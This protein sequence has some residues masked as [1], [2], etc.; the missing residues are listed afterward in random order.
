MRG[1]R[2]VSNQRW[3]VQI[4]HE[5]AHNEASRPSTDAV[6]CSRMC[7]VFASRG[8]SQVSLDCQNLASDSEKRSLIAS[9]AHPTGPLVSVTL[10]ASVSVLLQIMAKVTIVNP[11]IDI[12]SDEED[13]Q[14]D[15]VPYKVV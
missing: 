11:D 10:C 15:F 7:A 6:I 14:E 4:N 13:S 1:P 12:S 5:R 3:I 2:K 8:E 9:V